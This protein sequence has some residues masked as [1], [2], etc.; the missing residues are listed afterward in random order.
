VRNRWSCLPTA[1]AIAI[2][3]KV[4][5]FILHIGHDG[6]QVVWPGLNEPSRRRGFHVQECIDVLS[7]A[8]YAVTP[9]EMF[10][11]ITPAFT[12]PAYTIVYGGSPEAAMRRFRDLVH[13]TNGVI[14]GHGNVTGHAV[15]YQRGTVFDP[16][17]Q[18][19]SFDDCE[20]HGFTP[21]TAWSIT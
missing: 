20:K 10:P 12:V 11:C 7:R 2:G 17:G 9:F 6:S 1:F 19:Y 13:R 8:G 21:V 18:I 15:A 4:D 14:T 3:W 16:N 5:E